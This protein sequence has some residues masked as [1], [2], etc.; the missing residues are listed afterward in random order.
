MHEL[1]HT[2]PG[3][4]LSKIAINLSSSASLLKEKVIFPF[5]ALLQVNETGV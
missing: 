1:N 3:F 2:F 5:P 4:T